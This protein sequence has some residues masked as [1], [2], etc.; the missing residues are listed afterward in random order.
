MHPKLLIVDDEE[1]ICKQ[2]KWGLHDRYEVFTAYEGNEAIKQFRKIKPDIVTLDVTLSS[3]EDTPNGFEVLKRIL[4]IDPYVKVI[5]ITG[6]SEKENAVNALHI[7]AHD[8]YIKPI[9]LQELK[10]ILDR[11]LYIRNLELE[12]IQPQSEPEEGH[13]FWGIFCKCAKMRKIMNL[14]RKV[15]QTDLSILIGGESGTGKELAAQAI[16][17]CSYR[18]DKPFV[19]IDSGAIP[20]N[21][22]ESELFGHEKGAFTDAHSKRIGKIESAHEGTLFFDEIA[23]LPVYLQV[24]LLRFLQEKKIQRIGGNQLIPVDVRVIAATNKNLEHEVEK[25]TFR[26]DIYFRLSGVVIELP[27]LRERGEDIV[28]LAQWLMEK[29]INEKGLPFKRLTV[30][31]LEAI[32]AYQW[33][34]NVRELENRIKRA[35]ALSI[36]KNIKPK[37]LGILYGKNCGEMITLKEATAK[38]EKEL[39]SNYLKKFN[40]NLSKVSESLGIARTTVYDLIKKYKIEK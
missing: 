10:V 29:Y 7:G 15:A 4:A 30:E 19:P 9:D 37:D 5:M 31:S 26:E 39:L 20:K 23:E 32:E 28:L 17:K 27:P 35:V 2:L 36:D 38:V 13:E 3:P 18:A 11:A 1:I 12:S 8:Y 40:G 14:I 6:Q 16:H 24:K 34:G 25:G 21:L 22:L 33:P